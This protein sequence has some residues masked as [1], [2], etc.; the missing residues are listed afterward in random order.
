M[1]FN[2]ERQAVLIR[3]SLNLQLQNFTIMAWIKRGDTKNVTN[4]D[5]PDAFIFGYG[6]GGYFLGIHPDGRLFLSKIDFNNVCANCKVADETYHH[7]AVS[8]EGELIVFYVDGTAC[9]AA[10]YNP[11][12]EFDTDPSVGGRADTL[13]C[14]FIGSIDEV[15]VFNRAL[16]GEEVEGI[17]ESQK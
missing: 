7:V 11:G 1:S 6:R 10:N 13:G 15:A 4:T 9:P 16:S 17:Y 3:N 8:K 12:F 5:G 14:S 2:G